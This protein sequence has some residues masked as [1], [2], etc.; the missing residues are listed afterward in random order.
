LDNIFSYPYVP[1]QS[2][3]YAPDFAF[4]HNGYS[5]S[6]FISFSIII[7]C[8]QLSPLNVIFAGI[9]NLPHVGGCD[10]LI[11]TFIS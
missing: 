10:S 1:P 11:V 3:G 6:S 2:S 8:T 4:I 7:S 9:R 5:I